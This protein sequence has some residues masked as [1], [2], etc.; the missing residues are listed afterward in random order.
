M[1]VIVVGCG[2]L[3]AELAYRLYLEGHDVAVVD[4]VPAAFDVL[5]PDYA[6]RLCEGDAMN[7]DVLHRAGI[8]TADAVAVVTSSDPLNI[9]VGHVARTVFQVPNVVVRNYS[10][11]YRPLFEAFGLQV[12][13]ATSWGAQRV[14]EMIYESN[15]QSVLSTGN[16]E[17]EVYEFCVPD[18]WA[19]KSI[20][21]IFNQAG[22][23]V[24][25][26]T[27]AGKAFIPDSET[28]LEIGDLMHVSA[29]FKGFELIQNL[30]KVSQE[31]H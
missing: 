9:V 7:Y 23:V 8:E 1:K 21:E 16:G 17:V 6:G 31:E 11:E 19:A 10:P 18:Q 5:P 25:S 14:L 30:L 3:G 4:I 2:R 29:T 24:V 27:R 26:I 12:V 22:V 13:S 28:R 15:I 20:G